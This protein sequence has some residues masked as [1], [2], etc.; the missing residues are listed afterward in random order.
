MFGDR[1]LFS[2]GVLHFYPY[3]LCMAVGIIACFVFLYLTFVKYNFND[4][5]IDKILLI[6]IFATAFGV[7]MS[8]IFQALY[9]YIE[10]PAGGYN[11]SGSMT[12]QGGL[13][14]GVTSF[15]LVWNLYV[16]VIAPRTKIKAL[17]NNMNA[18][19][20]D[21]NYDCALL[22]APRLYVCGLLPRRKD[23]RVVRH[24]YVRYLL[25][26][27]GGKGCAHTAIR[28]HIPCAAYGCYDC[29]SF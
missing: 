13:I 18:S 3:G 22:R 17:K 9:D 19:L 26:S 14:G 4:E 29:A 7:F 21:A 12:F 10:D 5:A 8:M 6:G 23:G 11:L 15:L 1:P 28:V 2:L 25:R 20:T 16:F 27:R 24:C